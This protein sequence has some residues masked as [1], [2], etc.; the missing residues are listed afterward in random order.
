MVLIYFMK[1]YDSKILRTAI[2]F[3]LG[4]AAGNLIDRIFRPQGVV[5]FLDFLIGSYHF[6][7]FN[8]ADSFVVI[9]TI[10]LAYYMLFV[11]KEK[12]QN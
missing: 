10:V 4:G 3:I 9:G 6:P 11:Y 7:T 5:D 8:V 2:S 1:K 12:E